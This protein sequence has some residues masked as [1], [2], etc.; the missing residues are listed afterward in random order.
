MNKIKIVENVR[1]K[2]TPIRSATNTF[3]IKKQNEKTTI[4]H[5]R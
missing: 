3:K 1:P 4:V 2:I 5:T